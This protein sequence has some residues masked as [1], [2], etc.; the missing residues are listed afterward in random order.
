MMEENGHNLLFH[1][2]LHCIQYNVLS[3]RKNKEHL[4]EYMDFHQP[5]QNLSK[6]FAS[7]NR[8]NTETNRID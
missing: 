7:L 6:P 5:R 1:S 8:R 4:K 2:L 3:E